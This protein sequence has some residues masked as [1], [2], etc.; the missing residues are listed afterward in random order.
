MRNILAAVVLSV[1]ASVLAVKLW[2]VPQT[3]GEAHKESAYERV[4]RTGVLRCGYIVWPPEM[5]KDLATGQLSGLSFEIA[6]AIAAKMQVKVE[7]A[8]EVNFSTMTEGLQRGRYDA[9]CFTS[10]RR[11]SNV[12]GGAAHTLPLFYSGTGAF[13]RA[14]DHRFD[15]DLARAISPDITVSGMDGE[16]SLTVAQEDFPKAKQITL[17]QGGD[18]ASLLLNVVNGKADIAFVNIGNAKAFLQNNPQK[19]RDVA[20]G[21]PLRLY[22]HTFLLPLGENDLKEAMDTAIDELHNSGVMRRILNN[23]KP[24]DGVWFPPAQLY[25]R[26]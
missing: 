8:E 3:G 26:L 5:K 7:W 11:T 18:F 4:M 24:A 25:G 16:E 19:L 13:V 15:G 20:E 9:L 22:T 21:H 12:V 6:E 17:P 2:V 1:L 23:N 10:Y 14:D